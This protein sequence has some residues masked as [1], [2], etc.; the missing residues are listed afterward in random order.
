MP[1]SAGPLQAGG[2]CAVSAAAGLVMFALT[3][4]MPAV[5]GDPDTFWHVA[6]WYWI[7]GHAAVPHIDPFSHTRA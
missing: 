4:F 3:L 6:A 2:G 7:I 1:P 5:L